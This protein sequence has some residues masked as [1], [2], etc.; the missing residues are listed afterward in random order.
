MG[1]VS[2]IYETEPIGNTEQ[3][4]FLNLVCQVYTGLSPQGLLI[5]AKGIESKLGRMSTKSGTPR[6]ID[7]DILFY[8]DQVV[9]KPEL[10]IPHPRLAE[11]LFVLIP[12]VEIAGDLKHPVMC[13]T[14]REL[15]DGMSVVQSVFK[16]DDV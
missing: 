15:L 14:A 13:K 2:S 12:L 10:V 11:R 1:Q 4:D 7:I 6:P 5:L 9:K 16:W 3:P 8:G